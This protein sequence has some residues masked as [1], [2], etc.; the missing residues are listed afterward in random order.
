MKKLFIV[1][2]LIPIIMSCGSDKEKSNIQRAKEAVKVKVESVKVSHEQKIL[3][4]SGSIE[5]SQTIPLTFQSMEK[6]T[7]IYVDEGDFVKKGQLLAEVD[8]RSLQS[9]LKAAE[10]QYEQAVDARDRLKKVYDAGS[11]PEIKWVDTNSKV[12]QAEANRDHNKKSL[13]NCELRAPEDGYVGTRNIEVGMR[14]TQ[15]QAP[16]EIVQIKSVYAKISVPENEIGLFERGMEARVEVAAL[17][18][19]QYNG[20]VEKVG[21]V[22]NRLS[23]TYDVKID[24][25]NSDLKLKPGMVCKVDVILPISHEVLLVP[26]SAVDCDADN[27]SF[28]LIVEPSSNKA[29]KRIIQEDGIVNNNISVLSGLKAGDQVVVQG[30]QKITKNTEVIW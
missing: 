16:I 19:Q 6:V 26:M 8:R 10:A 29:V 22:A 11:L 7:R 15:I 17:N 4:F 14:A 18:N 25:T 28:V 13:E 27:N 24:V 1:F 20:N 9:A 5:A 2:A 3:S 23:R 12:A 30:N 21:V